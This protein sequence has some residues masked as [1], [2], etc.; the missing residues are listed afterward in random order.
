MT[1]GVAASSVRRSGGARPPK[2]PNAARTVGP[3]E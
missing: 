3:A 1:D 2:V